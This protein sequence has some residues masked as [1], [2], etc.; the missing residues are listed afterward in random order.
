MKLS[1]KL[2]VSVAAVSIATTTAVAPAMAAPKAP[3]TYEEQ[4]QQAELTGK[5]LDNAK[6][7]VDTAKTIVDTL[8]GLG[9]LFGVNGGGQK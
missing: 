1:R 4:V 6:K 2:A 5:R 8:G 7:G 9:G 3:K